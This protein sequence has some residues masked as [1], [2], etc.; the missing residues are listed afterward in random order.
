MM[1]VL[2]FLRSQW[3]LLAILAAAAIAYGA[4]RYYG[5]ARYF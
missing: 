3:K 4:L 1:G 5:N 2:L